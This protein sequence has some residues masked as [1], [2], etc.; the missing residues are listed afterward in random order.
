M[1]LGY[2][3][4][5]IWFSILTAEIC[6]G[7]HL[8][9]IRMRYKSGVSVE[10]TV[11]GI[12]MIIWCCLTAF[13]FLLNKQND[14]KKKDETKLAEPGI[15]SEGNLCLVIEI[16]ENDDVYSNYR[17]DNVLELVEERFVSHNYLNIFGNHVGAQGIWTYKAIG[18][19][20]CELYKIINTPGG[21]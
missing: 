1:D 10:M 7:I 18:Q 12:M 19:G 13:S 4:I 14:Q 16:D 20:E 8:L 21:G 15:D 3:I 2:I 17:G 11:L 6:L 9:I 5:A